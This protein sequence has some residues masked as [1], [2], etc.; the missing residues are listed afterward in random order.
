MD[1]TPESSRLPSLDGWRAVS[2][3]IVLAAHSSYL[4]GFPAGLKF[5]VGVL[6]D[7]GD[8][9]VRFFFVISGFLITWLLLGEHAASSGR[10]ISLKSFYIR[11]VLRIFPVYFFF[12]AVVLCLQMVTPFS[13]DTRTWLGNL[14]FSTNFFGDGRLT[15]HLWSLAIEEQFYLL[16]PGTFLLFGLAANP[17][18]AFGILAVPS[19]SDRFPGSWFASITIP[20]RSNGFFVIFQR[21]V[22]RIPSHLAAFARS[23]CFTSVKGWPTF[24]GKRADAPR[25]LAFCSWASPC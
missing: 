1:K 3:A 22:L 24:C 6:T 2:I 14:T 23:Y 11:R 7:A 21:R 10:G 8:L 17:R 12:L 4:A 9:G 20:M 13:Q 5:E 25:R 16:W 19:S 18:R 15:G